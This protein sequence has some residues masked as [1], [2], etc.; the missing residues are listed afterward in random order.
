MNLDIEVIIVVEKSTD[1]TLIV[2][3]KYIE[4]KSIKT[5]VQFQLIDNKVH[6]GKGFAVK[7]GM[8]YATGEYIFFCDADLA[9][10]LAEV[11][12]ICSRV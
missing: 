12:K 2:A 9:T 3:E 6:R 1:K 4:D 11:F 5:C 10:P 8:Q 7:S